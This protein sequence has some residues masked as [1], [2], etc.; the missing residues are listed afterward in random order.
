M[1]NNWRPKTQLVRAGLN[2]SENRETSEALFMS[3]GF[4]YDSA[5]QAE[6]SFAGEAD[7][8]VYSRYGNP[9]VQMLEARLAVLEGA[10]TCRATGTGMAAI[11]ASMACMLEAGDRVVASRALFG[12]CY[13]I[14][15]KILPRWGVETILVD[16]R[17]LDEWEAA[18]SKPAKIVFLESPSNP[19]LHL[20]DI[21][22]VA[23][24]AHKAGAKL[25]VDN[26]FAT[27]L[28]QS[29]LAL[30]ADVVVYSATKHID[31]QGRLLAGA[32]LGSHDYMDEFFVP[33]YRQTG[34]AISAFNAWV[35]LKSLET[36]P[37]RI[38]AMSQTASALCTYLSDHDAISAVQ[39]PG[40]ESHPQYALAQ[41]QMSGP[42]SVLAFE[43]KGGKNAAFRFLN[44]LELID[45]SN[46]LGDSKS[47]ACH[48]ASTTHSN[49]TDEE[50]VMV[51][52]EDSHIRLSVGLED[53][54]DLIADLEQALHKS[55]A[56][57]GG[58]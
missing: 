33:F 30:G 29:P 36:L 38:D 9:T 51:E 3:S 25:M 41:A 45:I 31:G 1:Q 22:A 17:N 35:M 20:V 21:A 11:F 27:P 44:A 52:I 47:L 18:L 53:T 39:F 26:V 34:S 13:A 46:N 4:V 19:L 6:A 15:T 8:F 24:M 56:H 48:P 10:E 32:V 16:G 50:R 37:L 28:Y 5:E 40:H 43:I 7:N 42:G 57:T 14:L 2:R 23:E 54:A 55:V 49:L 12:A 58:V